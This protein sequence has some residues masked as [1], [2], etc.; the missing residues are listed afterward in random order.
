MGGY[1]LEFLLLLQI[2]Y[3]LGIGLGAALN[4]WVLL[5]LYQ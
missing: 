2:A 1:I 5:S 3:I 4:G